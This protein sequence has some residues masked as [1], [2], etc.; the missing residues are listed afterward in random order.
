MES[1]LLNNSIIPNHRDITD[2]TKKSDVRLNDRLI[3][4][5]TDVNLVDIIIKTPRAPREHPYAS[6]I[7]RFAM[8]PS[9][10]SSGGP[11]TGVRATP[12]PF[13]SP[14]VP[15]A[16]P[17]VTLRSKTKGGP[18][19]HEVLETPTSENT[20]KW[21]GDHGFIDRPKPVRGVRH[22]L[23]PAPTKAVLPNPKLPGDLT[24]SE[25]THNMSKSL[26]KMHWITSYQMDYKGLQSDSKLDH[27]IDDF[28]IKADSKL[29][30]KIDDDMVKVDDTTGRT[31]QSAPLRTEVYVQ[32]L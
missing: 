16:P 4:K 15:P 21:T 1:P 10:R 19:R 6:H 11:Q 8:F 13:I 31:S 23:Y 25:R 12:F 20:A 27:K 32:M 26:D 22:A 24:A 7:S 28:M 17:N 9:F 29:D 30:H 3:P 18:Y 2:D 14:I 5:P